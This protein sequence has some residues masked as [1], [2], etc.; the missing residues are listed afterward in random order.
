M[1]MYPHSIFSYPYLNVDNISE[2]IPLPANLMTYSFLDNGPKKKIKLNET[3]EGLT[4]SIH[5]VGHENVHVRQQIMEFAGA[6]LSDLQR[7]NQKSLLDH[8]QGRLINPT[9]YFE[10]NTFLYQTSQ[11]EDLNQSQTLLPNLNLEGISSLNIPSLQL[12]MNEDRTLLASTYNGLVSSNFLYPEKIDQDPLWSYLD[13]Q[14]K[15][16]E[17]FVNKINSIISICAIKLGSSPRSNQDL[18]DGS[19]SPFQR[20]NNLSPRD[21]NLCNGEREV[22]TKRNKPKN[23]Q[24]KRINKTK[25]SFSKRS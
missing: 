8:Y 14:H 20:R 12:S 18:D 3:Q 15:D 5:N 16:F 2:L 23:K 17:E 21:I 10:Y 19:I 9:T 25:K 22:R 13:E 4:N 7:T 11:R 6:G 24:P 1:S